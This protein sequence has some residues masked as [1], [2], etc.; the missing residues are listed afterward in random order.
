[1]LLNADFR[2]IRHILAWSVPEKVRPVFTEWANGCTEP[3]EFWNG[4][5]RFIGNSE[6]IDAVYD[7][8]DFEITSIAYFCGVTI[9][10]EISIRDTA[11]PT[12]QANIASLHLHNLQK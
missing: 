7:Y 4:V 3:D 12:T 9:N 8:I 10:A 6:I 5:T 11:L 1:M 2:G